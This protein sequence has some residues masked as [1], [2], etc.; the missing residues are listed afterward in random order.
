MHARG[1]SRI[2]PVVVLL[3]LLATSAFAQYRASLQ[4]TVTDP[5]GAAVPGAT[6]TVK[7]NE[8][9]ATRHATT[10]DTGAY[11]IPS[12]P[13]G[14]YTITTEKQGFRTN[15]IDNFRI[16]ADQTQGANIQLQV[17]D[18]SQS[19]TVSAD[20]IE[21]INTENAQVSATITSREIQ[22]LP[23]FGRDIFQLAQL[24]PGT[25]GDASRNS[26]GDTNSQPG[27]AG[28]GGS[29]GSSGVFSTENRPQFSANGGRTNANAVNLDGVSISSVSWGGAAIITPN[30][31]SVKEVR[32]VSNS[33]DAEYGRFGGGQVQVISQ[34]GTNN[35]H[36]SL[37]FKADREG[38]N[39]YQD[40][41]GAEGNQREPQINTNRFND[42]G[43][44]V[45][46]PI[47][48]NKLF[49][50]FSYDTIRN[51]S[52]DTGQGW[53]E[54]PQLLKSA[55]A[56][57]LAARYGAYAGML[58]PTNGIIDQTCASIS[59]KEGINC[60]MIPGQGLD[61]GRPLMLP[62]GTKDPSFVNNLNPG[63]GGDGT[64]SPAN[65]D[66]IADLMFTKVSGAKKATN[67]QF[68]GRVDFQATSNDLV[69]FSMYRVPV[70]TIAPNGF[71]PANQF[72]H[73]ATNE[74][75][76]I[77]W[78]RTFSPTFLNELRAN[79][80][81]WRWNE[82]ASNPQI[83]L[84][85]PQTMYI[86]DPS[87]GNQIGTAGGAA[88]LGGPAGS[89]F[90]QW[91]Y[92][93]KD[94]ATKVSG[95]HTIKFGGEVTKLHFLQDA[96]WSARPTYGFNNYW[97]FLND[98]PSKENGTFNPQTGIPT[99][100]RKDSRQTLL[101]FF[102][103]DD[104]KA[105]QNLTLNFGLRWEHFG[106]P[107][108]LRDQLSSV[109]LGQGDA[110][111]TGM[112]MRIG[113]SLYNADK[114]NFAPQIGFAWSPGKIRGHELNNKLAIRGG[115]GIGYTGEQQAILLNGWNN[116]P[117]T[118]NGTDLTGNQIVYDFPTNPNQFQ[119]Y[120]ANPNTIET[121]GP[122]N[123]PV[124]GSPVGVTGFP[125]DFH[126]AY[127][128]RYSMDV[129]Y[130]FIPSWV[131]S[132]G[133][134]GSMS[135]HLTRQYNLNQVLGAKGIPLNPMVNNVDWYSPDGK[136]HSNALLFT[137]NHNFS[138]QFQFN[139][140]Y[141]YSK[142]MDNESGPYATSYY[143][144]N[145]KLDWGASDFDVRHLVKFYGIYS[146]TIFRGDHSWMEKIF[147]GWSVSSIV[148]WHTGYPWTPAIFGSC[149][150]VYAGGN[151]QNGTNGSLMPV[152]YLGGASDNYSNST[153][154]TQGGNFKNG[155]A[156]SYFVLPSAITPCSL[157]FPQT[158]S[159]LPDPPG[160]QRNSFR[161]PRY[162]DVDATLSKAFGLPKLPVLGE[163]ARFEFRAN[164]FNLFN[165]TNLTGVVS[166][167]N[168][169]N[170]GMALD[171]LGGRT[172]E[173]QA[174]FSF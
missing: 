164:A 5:T 155:P 110:A 163:G 154:L 57:S 45:G 115:V 86:G 94:T 125:S 66:G 150:I 165:N 107:S 87:G 97:D 54:T 104:F 121:F 25:V 157:P 20:A 58:M 16:V 51:S 41:R 116:I 15:Q 28:P 29:G 170:F 71:R 153:F 48:K 9:N 22:R 27:N 114:A 148:N 113:G 12:L 96:P 18:V 95:S 13:P 72:N 99:D 117:F 11:S 34:N 73:D 142:S 168:S 146:P 75:E 21:A 122:N 144:W 24:A 64:G 80:A 17:G 78:N 156:S 108:F 127:T 111:L 74:A 30:E 61:I 135:R 130:E 140:Q 98:A 10:T 112:R 31:D 103:Q 3:V 88:S 143:Q 37:F 83:P 106:A 19:V 160:I 79:A 60:H 129:Q 126:T 119:P 35:Y 92:S 105:R 120:P 171:A 158:C 70:S 173:L 67:Q 169:S 33:Y 93:L 52:T 174:R 128:Y 166:D 100:V 91:T 7:S 77:L 14:L 42:Y 26:S 102:V 149:D 6:V 84:G 89:I 123:I 90:D 82:L 8:T 56:G 133:Y 69:A 76:T 167:I 161:G 137:L 2:L 63:L 109:E 49:G 65:L 101:G 62:L 46:G 36:G 172:I 124:A 162:F 159:N 152:R 32:V 44:S 136:A 55:P 47:L 43:G 134:Q 147:G 23:S 141:R 1:S 40:W 4:G 59:L 138:R 85:L 39:A 131:G 151:C 68:N 118:N 38:L 139:A 132:I 53:Y 50:F 145:P 81:G